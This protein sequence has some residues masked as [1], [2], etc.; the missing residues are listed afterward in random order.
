MST[1]HPLDVLFLTNFSDYCFR[2]IPAVA[3]MAAS[4]KVRLTIM[5][6]YDPSHSSQKDAEAHLHSF[7]PEADRYAACQRVAVQGPLIPAV[8][9]HLQEWPV[10]LLIAPA[11]DTVGL[12]RLGAGSTRSRLVK[13]C[14]VPVWTIGRRVQLQSI[15]RPAK[16]VACWLDFYSPQTEHL[17]FAMEYARKLGAKLH[18]LRALPNID[19][20]MLSVGG[21]DSALTPATAAEEILRLCSGAV[22]RPEVHVTSGEGRT[23]LNRLLRQCNADVVFLGRESSWIAE[24]MGM[25]LHLG[26]GVPC[27]AV[28]VGEH[29]TIPVWSLETANVTAAPPAG[30]ATWRDTRTSVGSGRSTM[31]TAVLAELGL[32]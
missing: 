24:W 20:G 2:S 13:T 1:T 10:N 30:N 7:F 28:Y 12:P 21:Q 26:D 8:Q 14:G 18:L 4:L 32:I 23:S 16:N 25:G 19:E 22:G 17:A 29:L 3:Q 11:S 15:A 5:H 6:A 27:P 31:T 9:R